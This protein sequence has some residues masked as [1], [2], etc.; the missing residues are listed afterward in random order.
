[1]NTSQDHFINGAGTVQVDWPSD[2]HARL[3]IMR[4][5]RHNALGLDELAGLASAANY[6]HE[7]PPKV[8]SIVAEGPNFGVGGDINAFA[9]ALSE[10]QME[11]WLRTAIGYYNIAISQLRAL[12]AAVVVGIQ[13]ASAGGTLGLVWC[14][15]HVIFTEDA[16]I[17]MA[18]AK[19]GGSP[20]G[21]TSWLLSKLVNP[22]R[23]F[24]M[25]TLISSL[26]AEKALDWGLANQI[27]PTAEIIKSVDAVA[28]QWLNLPTQS[29][30]NIKRLLR[31]AQTQDLHAHLAQELE[32][33]VNASKQPEFSQRIMKFAKST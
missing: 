14:A 6:L 30:I 21:G 28:M 33:F 7:F 9:Q 2:G 8:L 20:D 1:M 23:S 16:S 13:G 4:Q 29:L 26:N 32:G 3:K 5:A 10:N 25:F 12:D 17:N 31:K 27:V 15:D 11:D 18:Y 24:E 19:L 22:L